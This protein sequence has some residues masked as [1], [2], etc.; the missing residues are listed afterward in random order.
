MNYIIYF[1]LL[2]SV[3]NVYAMRHIARKR[4][5]NTSRESTQSSKT[6]SVKDSF[7]TFCLIND[8]RTISADLVEAE[9][10][11][12]KMYS[13]YY[14]QEVRPLPFTIAEGLLIKYGAYSSAS[15]IPIPLS[16]LTQ[17][18]EVPLTG[19]EAQP[20][21]AHSY[22]KEFE[23]RVI[24]DPRVIPQELFPLCAVF[25]IKKV[26]DKEIIYPLMSQKRNGSY[27]EEQC[28]RKLEDLE[29]LDERYLQE[30]EK[31]SS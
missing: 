16:I 21:V 1:F 15:Q 8:I 31:K 14:G 28:K 10:K 27:F 12:G 7:R 9:T 20:E 4:R 25:M 23:K 11:Q 29:A 22:V 13:C 3:F 2:C 26:D 5:L 6:S 19:F 17:W 18:G 24:K 30:I